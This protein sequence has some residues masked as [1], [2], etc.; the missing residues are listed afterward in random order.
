MNYHKTNHLFDI[1]LTI[2]QNTL[3]KR[4]G[5]LIKIIEDWNYI[6]TEEWAVGCS[7]QK[8]LWN[9]SNQGVLYISCDNVYKGQN[10]LYQKN[11]IMNKLN[12]Y[13]GFN[14]IID[15]KIK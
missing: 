5:H 2:S 6:F 12:S 8:I 1:I 10:L 13:F 4:G 7:P 3:D 11:I 15:V 14:C 9:K